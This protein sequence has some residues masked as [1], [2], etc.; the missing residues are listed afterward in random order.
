VSAGDDAREVGARGGVGGG[1]TEIEGDEPA[2]G[3]ASER[4][5]CCWID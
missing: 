5:T 1:G 4:A 3:R 2:G